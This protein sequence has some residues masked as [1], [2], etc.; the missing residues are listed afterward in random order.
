[1]TDGEVFDKKAKLFI[2]HSKSDMID[3]DGKPLFHGRNVVSLK[4][5]MSDAERHMYDIV[6]EYVRRQ[7]NLSRGRDP[8]TIV[9][10]ALLFIQKRMASSTR[11]LLET[12]KR[13]YAKLNKRLEEW[14]GPA[15]GDR[16][17]DVYS[18]MTDEDMETLEAEAEGLTQAQ[19]KDE[20]REEL[21]E[22]DGLIDTARV[23]AETKPDTKLEKLLSEIENLGTDQLL[24]FSEY[25][26]T[27]D[28]LSKNIKSHVAGLK[29]L[30]GVNYEICRIDGDMDMPSRA[31]AQ[32]DFK[33]GC[34]IMLATDAAREGINLQFCHRM[35]NYD[36]PWSPIAL[37]QRMGRLHRYG[38]NDEVLISNMV[39]ADTLEGNVME[40]LFDK[41][42]QIESQYPTFNVMGH[43]L[44]GGDLDGL[45]ADVIR[46]GTT[47]DVDDKVDKAAERARKMDDMLGRSTPVDV[48][49]IRQK[50][51]N[52]K[53]Q[54]TDGKHLVNAATKLFESLGG[55][56][57]GTGGKTSLVVPQVLHYGPFGKK[58]MSLD[59]TPSEVLARGGDIYDHLM[60]W[61]R[62]N[63]SNDL[64]SGSVFRDAGGRDGWILFHT[65]RILNKRQDV[66]GKQLIAH[67]LKSGGELE[68]VKPFVLHDMKY[69]QNID[70]GTAPPSNSVLEA[71]LGMARVESERIAAERGTFWEYRINAADE[72][73]NAEKEM[74]GKNISDTGF[75]NERNKLIEERDKLDRRMEELLTDRDT[76]TV[77]HADVPVFEGWV[78]VVPATDEPRNGEPHGRPGCGENRHGHEHGARAF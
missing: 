34:Q 47:D 30:D 35:V 68:N 43:V 10:F 14:N 63:C 56:I 60:E 2:R 11:A 77:L 55:S 17:L 8:N 69:A 7:Y 23:A 15:D 41:I 54:R 42:R 74:I 45:I 53:A 6:S 12:L 51:A 16:V 40:K 73:L 75:G 22:L 65:V 21:V 32:E 39:A 58:R 59:G 38:Q 26:D 27:L 76:E 33:K 24:I 5:D 57:R 44:V 9:S 66:A 72:R 46:E 50:I 13:R 29:Q 62:S 19:T 70:A 1:M 71:V 3:M 48:E 52:I 18:S 61:V 67:F 64:K 31:V 36:L 78:R 25:K 49:Q 28:Y 37:E 20:L 4:Y